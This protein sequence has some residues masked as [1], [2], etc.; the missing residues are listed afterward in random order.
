[1]GPAGRARPSPASRPQR[2][3]FTMFRFLAAALLPLALAACARADDKPDLESLAA[4][5]N[6]FAFDLYA[7]LREGKGNVFVSPY[8]IVTALSTTSAGAR[9]TTL[10]E[11]ERALSLPDQATLH[12]AARALLKQVNTPSKD[13]GAFQLSTANALWGQKGYGFREEFL[14]T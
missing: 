3:R 8:S 5:H 11:M 12:P 10:D 14:K 13:K 2:R 6:R 9:G 7:K 1:A 4:R